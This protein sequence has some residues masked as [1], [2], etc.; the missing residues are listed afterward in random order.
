[1]KD[2]IYKDASGEA[3]SE[4]AVPTTSV[5]ATSNNIPACLAVVNC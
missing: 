5:V 4:R 1:M 3:Y 2:I